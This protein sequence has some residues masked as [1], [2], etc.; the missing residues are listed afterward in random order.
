MR[1]ETSGKH[2]QLVF[3]SFADF[4]THNESKPNDRAKRMEQDPKFHGGASTMDAAL[5]MARTGLPREGIDA[6][7]IAESNIRDMDRDLISQQFQSFY[8]VEGADVDVA[9]YLT[10][11]PECM[12]NYF[13]DDS[14][15][16]RRVV[17]VVTQ[18]SVNCNVS[19][20]AM[21]EH[22]RKLVALAEAIDRAGVQSELWVDMTVDGRGH[23]GRVSI[24]LKAPGELF[25]IGAFMF[26]LTHPVMFRGLGLNTFHSFPKKFHK[27]LTVGCGYG[28]ANNSPDIHP[29]DYPEGTTFIP[30]IA[31]DY[32]AGFSVENTLRELGL[33]H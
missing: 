16:V 28:H 20:E 29:G 2:V 7:N 25:D 11:E 27:P 13:M 21:T 12:I 8:D 4:I 30:G 19:P 1:T 23:T 26:A 31:N 18:I 32:E 24:R 33:M 22:G 3:D 6:L 15:S 5:T 14:T 10:G 9:R 17:T